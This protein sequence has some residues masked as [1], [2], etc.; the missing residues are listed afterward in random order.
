MPNIDNTIIADTGATK[1]YLKPTAPVTKINYNAKTSTISTATR[2]LL[3]L[4]AKATINIPWLPPGTS[5]G[6]IMP[7]FVNNLL[8]TG[9]FCD[10]NCT[11]TFTKTNVTVYN[12]HGTI[13]LW[14]I[15]ESNGA[16]MWHINLTTV[17]AR[18]PTPPHINLMTATANMAS[19]PTPAMIP[20]IIPYNDDEDS[21]DWPQPPQIIQQS[22]KLADQAP[23]DIPTKAPTP[24]ENTCHT[25]IVRPRSNTYHLK[26]YN[27]PSIRALIEY[28]H[29][30]LGYPVKSVLLKAIKRG[31]LCSFPGLSHTSASRYCPDNATPN[32][33]GHMTQVAKGIQLTK[34]QQPNQHITPL[35]PN[36]QPLP[37]KLH[38]YT[39]A[40]NTIFTDNMGQFPIELRSRNS[41][42]M[43][44][45]HVRANA[46]IIEP[47]KFKADTH[48]IPAHNAVMERMKAHGLSVNLQVLDNE[49]SATYIDCITN[50]WKCKHQK[51][52][53]D[54]H[55]RNIAKHMI[56]TFKAHLLSMLTGVDP[57]F[58]G[59]RWDLL[60]HQ[61]EITLNLL[62][63]S[64]I[65]PTKSTWELMCG[66]FNYDATPFGSPGCCI[67]MHSKG[68]TR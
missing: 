65:N 13:I 50:K 41:Y 25:P 6:K 17:T 15:R 35:L 60:L 37:N 2:Q 8:S 21:I 42:I 39:R 56:R 64:Q 48:Q 10:S 11:V 16:K 12:A 59:T 47:F 23:T 55:Q 61:A 14:V 28:H 53:P 26:A 57:R 3:Q 52:P 54:I 1:H 66:P 36:G 7:D 32:I 49:A 24:V 45:H 40:M 38:I 46:I 67:I 68:T 43:L 62:C 19:I 51:V 9:V 5:T 20:N 4:S 58:P 18:I 63:T 29:A 27:L 22:D 31:H 30:L 44:A 33:M 34:P